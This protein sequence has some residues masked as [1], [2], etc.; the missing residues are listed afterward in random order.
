M[1]FIGAS[2]FPGAGLEAANTTVQVLTK[3]SA[4]RILLIR[5]IDAYFLVAEVVLMNVFF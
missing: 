1:S 5:R 3:K 4:Q 2:L